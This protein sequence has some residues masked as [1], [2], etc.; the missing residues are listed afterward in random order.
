MGSYS[1]IFVFFLVFFVALSTVSYAQ[2]GNDY[3]VFGKV[4]DTKG[5]PIPGAK[6]TLKE[7]ETGKHIVMKTK[8]DGTFDQQFIPHAMY[9]LSVEKE[10]Y[11]TRTVDKVDMTR[12][13]EK[14]IQ[15]KIDV[16]LM[17]QQDEEQI[18]LAE[19]QVQMVK[20]VQE[21]YKKGMEQYNA[22][23][24][25]AALATMQEVSQKSPESYGP[26]LVSAACYQAK[27][28]PDNAIKY[29]EKTLTLKKDIPEVCQNLGDLYT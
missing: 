7:S 8:E 11:I 17:T 26:Y 4:T 13:G 10:G 9:S 29:Y 28:D 27:G 25:D 6:L 21:T 23:Q 22:K 15:R 24:F 1:R 19:Q 3:H 5:N 18:K 12:Y 16:V 14:P 20:E 2:V